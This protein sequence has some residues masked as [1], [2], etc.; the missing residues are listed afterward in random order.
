MAE[1]RFRNN[2]AAFRF[3]AIEDGVVISQIDYLMDGPVVSF[4]HTSTP[5]E[6]RG[7][8]LAADLTRF[9]LEHVRENGLKVMPL[10]PYAVSYIDGNPCY[11]D[12]V[13]R[14]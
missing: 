11:H 8:G 6:Y 1:V 10:C 12:L 2:L 5:A 14:N 9:A 7:R 4:T 3:E 13:A